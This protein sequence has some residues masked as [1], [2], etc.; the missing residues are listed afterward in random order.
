LVSV[1]R[2][3]VHGE[4]CHMPVQLLPSCSRDRCRVTVVA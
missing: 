4:I 1:R 3:L 2:S